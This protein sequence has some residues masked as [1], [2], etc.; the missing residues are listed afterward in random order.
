MNG[1]KVSKDVAQMLTVS[2]STY[3]FLILN[4]YYFYNFKKQFLERMCFI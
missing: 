3:C 4:M 1:I 2:S